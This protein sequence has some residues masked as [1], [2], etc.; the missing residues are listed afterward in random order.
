MPISFISISFWTIIDYKKCNLT[1]IWVWVYYDFQGT[2][3]QATFS[4]ASFKKA[5]EETT[6]NV[7]NEYFTTFIPVL[8]WFFDQ[9]PH[10]CNKV[11]QT[12]AS[13]P[14]VKHRFS[15]VYPP[16]SNGAVEFVCKEV[17]LEMHAF[18]SE[19][20]SSE[21]DWPKSVPAIQ[22]IINNPLSRRLGARAPITVDIGMPSENLLTVALTDCNIQDV[23][24][25]DQAK[26]LQSCISAS[27]SSLW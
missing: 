26:M 12:L 21:A 20:L 5:D 19:T 3:S 11:M 22:S 1:K 9:R 25:N 6:A 27:I 7:F 2:T 16:R 17:L 13:S 8:Q 4:P 10:F 24:R 14:G 15:T 18:N 23:E